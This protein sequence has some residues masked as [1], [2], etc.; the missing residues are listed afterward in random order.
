MNQ[1]TDVTRQAIADET[2]VARL[3]YPGKIEE[4][5]FLTQLFDLQHLPSR[6]PRYYNVYDD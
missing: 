3:W 6:D 4:P 5:D 2:S 1:I